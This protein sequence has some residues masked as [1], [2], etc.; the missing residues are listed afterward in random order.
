[1]DSISIQKDDATETEVDGAVV[2]VAVE[3]EGAPEGGRVVVE[4]RATP[5]HTGASL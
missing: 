3:A 2:R 4:P 1:V 5:Q